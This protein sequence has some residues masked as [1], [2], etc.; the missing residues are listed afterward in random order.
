MFVT[1]T[2]PFFTPQAIVHD[3]ASC[4]RVSGLRICGPT[5]SG[6][7]GALRF[8]APD[9]MHLAPGASLPVPDPLRIP[10]IAGRPTR[11]Q[12]STDAPPTPWKVPAGQPLPSVVLHAVDEWGNRITDPRSFGGDVDRFRC[13]ARGPDVA[14]TD[15]VPFTAAA[16]GYCFPRI[17]LKGGAHVPHGPQLESCVTF[18]F[19]DVPGCSLD[20]PLLVMPPAAAASARLRLSTAQ[21]PFLSASGPQSSTLQCPAGTMLEGWWVLLVP[22]GDMEPSELHCVCSW[23]LETRVPVRDGAAVLPALETPRRPGKQTYQVQVSRVQWGQRGACAVAVMKRAGTPAG[24]V[25]PGMVLGVGTAGDGAPSW[26]TARIGAR[27]GTARDRGEGGYGG[28]GAGGYGRA[29][30]PRGDYG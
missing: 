25:L 21:Q 5:P 19:A 11:L 9:A 18:S 14:A 29:L 6:G 7:H 24:G 1:P 26:G 20:L 28:D 30:V 10:V 17:C 13:V 12:L 15:P 22:A 23:A 8:R 16:G 2:P 3:D 4:L 27:E